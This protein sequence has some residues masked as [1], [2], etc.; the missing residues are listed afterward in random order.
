MYWY[1]VIPFWIALTILGL[2]LVI[3]RYRKT[4]SKIERNQINLFFASIFLLFLLANSNMI[5]GISFL[6]AF[7]PVVYVAVMSYAITRHRLFDVNLILKRGALAAGIIFLLL[8]GYVA[9]LQWILEALLTQTQANLATKVFFA[10]LFICLTFEFF[11]N[12]ASRWVNLLF[13]VK[14]FDHTRLLLECSELYSK[15]PFLRSYIPSLAQRLRQELDLDVAAL[16][17]MDLQTDDF[18]YL[19]VSPRPEKLPAGLPKGHLLLEALEAQKGIVELELLLSAFDDEEEGMPIRGERRAAVIAELRALDLGLLVPVYSESLLT[20]VLA[21]GPKRSGVMFSDRDITFLEALSNQVATAVENSRLYDSVAHVDRLAT[22]GTLA[23]GVAHEIRSP[24][25]AIMTYVALLPDRH[26]DAGWINRFI[27]IVKGQTIKLQSIANQL[28]GYAR[29]SFLQQGAVNLG[30]LVGELPQVIGQE[31][32][33]KMVRFDVQEPESEMS[34]LGEKGALSQVLTNL[35]LNALH[36]TK[37]ETGMVSV[38][39][40]RPEPAWVHLTVR[41]NGIGIPASILPK[42][43]Q[44]FFTTKQ[45]GT[46]L[47]LSISR[48]LVRSHGGD[49]TVS[50]VEGQGSE[51]TVVLPAAQNG[52]YVAPELVRDRNEEDQVIHGNPKDN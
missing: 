7:G 12:W 52:R 32:S 23:A 18:N 11:R 4:T 9:F 38:R 37:A 8:V 49:I 6:G 16:Y 28:T 48:R 43:F 15:S 45:D 2:G 24:I 51:F 22:I 30:A 17:L 13:R 20:A 46:G 29:K 3:S 5:P 33:K 36:A 10:A 35:C 39:V 44:A 14:E 41:D 25:S 40:T 31:F 34:T 1:C 42:L 26:Q 19:G 47:G 27:G 21:L 50:S